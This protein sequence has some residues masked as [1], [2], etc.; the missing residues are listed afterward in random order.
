MKDIFDH[1]ALVDAT[2]NYLMYIFDFFLVYL[3][4]H[5]STRKQVRI[6]V[7]FM[8]TIMWIH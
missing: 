5:F 8:F 6:A 4:M 2:Y 1:Q 7:L 3:L